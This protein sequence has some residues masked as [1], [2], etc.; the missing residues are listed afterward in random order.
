MMETVHLECDCTSAEHT[1]RFVL[2]DDEV[3]P[4]IYMS[5][6]LSRSHRFFRRLWMAIKHVFGYECKYGHWDEVMLT[7]PE[8]EI[9]RDMCDKH[10]AQWNKY[11]GADDGRLSDE[12]VSRIL[13]R[14]TRT[15]KS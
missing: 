1:V 2:D 12:D 8:V 9:L 11:N 5:V 3:Y 14:E 6:Q 10:L 15:T 7:G 4:H 13:W